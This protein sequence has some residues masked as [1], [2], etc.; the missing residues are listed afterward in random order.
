MTADRALDILAMSEQARWRE[1]IE[2]TDEKEAIETIREALKADKW[3]PVSERLPDKNVLVM[4]YVDTGTTRTYCLALWNDYYKAW[5]EGIGGY[6]LIDR[7]LGY[8]VLAWKPLPEP[9]KGASE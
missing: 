1:G 8:Q 7:D 9:Y 4:T 5:E 6:R 3:I 2:P